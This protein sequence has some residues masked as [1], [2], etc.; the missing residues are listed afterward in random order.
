ML[1]VS[2]RLCYLTKSSW[3]PGL[4]SNINGILTSF[5]PH[6][7]W[8]FRVLPMISGNSQGLMFLWP[9]LASLDFAHYLPFGFCSSLPCPPLCQTWGTHSPPPCLTFLLN[10]NKQILKLWGDEPCKQLKIE[11]LDV[12]KNPLAILQWP[13]FWTCSSPHSGS[14]IWFSLPCL[15]PL[16]LPLVHPRFHFWKGTLWLAMFACFPLLPLKLFKMVP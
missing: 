2:D 5:L 15:S 1:D 7:L 3:N 12:L 9:L 13:S 4:I 8:K 6:I 16:L 11:C 14:D 10:S